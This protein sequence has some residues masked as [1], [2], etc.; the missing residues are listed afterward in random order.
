MPPPQAHNML[1]DQVKGHQMPNLAPRALP[2]TLGFQDNH[3]KTTVA[4]TSTACKG[5]W[6]C[7][8]LLAPQGSSPHAPREVLLSPGAGEAALQDEP[9]QRCGA[10]SAALWVL[11]SSKFPSNLTH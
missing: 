10:G 7:L 11:Q 4:N 9:W 8:A 5:K 2:G 3:L 6:G 1:R